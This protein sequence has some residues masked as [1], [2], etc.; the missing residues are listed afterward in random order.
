MGE[1]KEGM[2]L[3]L[4]ARQLRCLSALC[5]GTCP[6]QAQDQAGLP[7]QVLQTSLLVWM[8]VMPTDFPTSRA[9]A[10]G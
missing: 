1:Y 9:L 4:V 3:A 2:A 8:N 5:A 6:P 10:S 7:F